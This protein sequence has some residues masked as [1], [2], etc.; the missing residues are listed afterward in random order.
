MKLVCIDG[1]Y[2]NVDRIDAVANRHI[3]GKI[4]PDV[5]NIFVG[6]S[7]DP[8]VVRLPIKEVVKI[9]TEQGEEE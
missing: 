7:D 2:F 9:L 5:S 4:I 8:W 1:I 6:G 3:Q